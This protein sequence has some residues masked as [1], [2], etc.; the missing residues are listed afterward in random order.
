MGTMVVLL[1]KVLPVFLVLALGVLC[2]KRALISRDGVNA[3]KKVAVDI[4]LPAV[5]FSAFATAE[6]SF[7]SVCVPLVMFV[8]CCIALLLGFLLCRR[9]KIG[10]RLSPYI[11]AGFEAGMLGY[12]LFSILFP[13]E[14][15]SSFAMV[16]LGQVL[17]VFTVYKIMLAGRS[18]VKDALREALSAPTVWAILLGLLVGAT[19]LYDALKPSGI[20]QVLDA[21]TDFVSAPTSVLILL[22]VG[23]DLSPSQIQ[24]KKIGSLIGLRLGVSALLLGAALLLDHFVLGRMMHSGALLLMFVLPPPYVLPVFADVEDER[25]DVSSALSALTFVSIILFAIMAAVM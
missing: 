9:L 21:L 14:K 10:G 15:V 11:A 3:L 7:K 24:W 22:A 5:M 20:S 8:L 18:N 23:Y 19:G 4:A 2:R 12:A 25:A 1:Q 13:G 16:D 6:Y 17:F